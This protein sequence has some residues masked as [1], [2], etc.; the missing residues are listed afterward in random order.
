VWQILMAMEEP[1]TYSSMRARGSL[2]S[3]ISLELRLPEAPLGPTIASG[4][5]LMGTADFNGDG[6]PDYVLYN[7]SP[8]Q[9]AIWYM[10]NN[11][12]AGGAFG[13]TLSPA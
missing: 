12:L 7:A 3:G 5:Q 13:A 4:Y 10:N 1:I 8:R 11:V 6:Y 9:T 2:R